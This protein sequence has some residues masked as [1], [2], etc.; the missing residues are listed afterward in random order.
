[1]SG[2]GRG[3]PKFSFPAAH[4]G[5]PL[6]LKA[7]NPAQETRMAGLPFLIKQLYTP[8]VSPQ[9]W[10]GRANL[11]SAAT[12]HPCNRTP[13]RERAPCLSLTQSGESRISQPP[14]HP[15]HPTGLEQ[16]WPL[17]QFLPSLSRNPWVLSATAPIAPGQLQQQEGAA[18][19]RTSSSQG[20]NRKLKL[21]STGSDAFSCTKCLCV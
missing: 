9:A 21:P 11:A 17:P 12:F 8:G 13:G 16:G 4:Q 20:K 19:W 3:T 18:V 5:A 6:G 7:R 10:E 1:M 14:A 15:L 2:Q